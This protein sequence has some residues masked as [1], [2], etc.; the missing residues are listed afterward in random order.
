M[1]NSFLLGLLSLAVLFFIC[2]VFVVGVK[3]ILIKFFYKPKPTPIVKPK[4]KKTVKSLT[5]NPDEIDRIY[6]KKVS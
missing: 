3:S 2:L 5:I 6:V 1:L 4:S